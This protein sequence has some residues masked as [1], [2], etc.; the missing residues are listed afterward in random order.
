MV[1]K[2]QIN[3]FNTKKKKLELSPIY[4]KIIKP[5]NFLNTADLHNI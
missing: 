2:I 1:I 5:K 4:E 3:A